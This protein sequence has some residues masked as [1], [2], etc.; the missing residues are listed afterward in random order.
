MPKFLEKEFL[1]WA[2]TKSGA[3]DYTD[4]DKCPLAQFGSARENLPY[5]GFISGYA[6]SAYS[7]SIKVL[8]LDAAKALAKTPYTFEALVA[9]L[10]AAL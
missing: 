6:L 5:R 8:G 10:E 2:R 7:D 1:N 3:Y 9:R 4:L